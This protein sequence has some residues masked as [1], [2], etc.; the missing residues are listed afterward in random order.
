MSA[1][2]GVALMF[3]GIVQKELLPVKIW[4]LEFRHGEHLQTF[5]GEHLSECFLT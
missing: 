1:T 5:G 4:R 3:A 2:S